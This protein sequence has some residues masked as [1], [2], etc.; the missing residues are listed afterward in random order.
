M[1]TV[2]TLRRLLPKTKSVHLDQKSYAKKIEFP[3]VTMNDLPSPEGDYYTQNNARQSK[4]NMHL[5]IG[6][7]SLI[8]TIAFGVAT[9]MYNLLSD[10]PEQPAEIDCYRE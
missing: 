5:M 6:V 3:Q 1:Q 10:V 8:G 2:K 9:D 7:G 4:Y